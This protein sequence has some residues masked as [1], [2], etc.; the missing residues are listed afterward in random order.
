MNKD[1]VKTKL[2]KK[3]ESLM[4]SD[5]HAFS[6]NLSEFLVFLKNNSMTQLI[7]EELYNKEIYAENWDYGKFS[8]RPGA[9]KPEFPRNSEDYASLSLSLL[10][11][12]LDDE[13]LAWQIGFQISCDGNPDSATLKFMEYFAKPLYEYIDE[14]IEDGNLILYFLNKFKVRSEWFRKNELMDIYESNPTKGEDNLTSELRL[15]LFDHGLEYHFSEPKTPS[16]R[17][18]L[19]FGNENNPVP[20]EVKLFNPNANYKE[21]YIRK[22]FH[23]SFRYAQDYNQPVGYYLIFN[24][25]DYDLKFDSKDQDGQI[26]VQYGDKI[27]FIVVINLFE[28]ESA[29][30]KGKMKPYLIKEDYLK[31]MD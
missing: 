10:E 11:K 31:S 24:L 2:G 6:R 27:I 29:S 23:Q 7:I 18:D 8:G 14:R 13:D 30:K 16:G 26:K 9:D 25:S 5:S 21:S 19:V 3:Y 4:F 17:P 15:F 28:N 12:C 1:I 22:G 20:L